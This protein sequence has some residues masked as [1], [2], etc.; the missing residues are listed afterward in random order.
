MSL[1]KQ[2]DGKVRNAVVSWLDRAATALSLRWRMW[3]FLLV[4]CGCSFKAHTAN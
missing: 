2:H 1:D 3:Q 4:E